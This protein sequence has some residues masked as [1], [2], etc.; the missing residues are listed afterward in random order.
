[1][2]SLFFWENKLQRYFHFVFL[3]ICELESIVFQFYC[4]LF[5]SSSTATFWI[6]FISCQWRSSHRRLLQ[7]RLLLK[8]SRILERAMMTMFPSSPSLLFHFSL[9]HSCAQLWHTDVIWRS[10]SHFWL[11]TFSRAL[12]DYL[13]I[14]K[15]AMVI[16]IL[17]LWKMKT[18]DFLVFFGNFLGGFP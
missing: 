15:H 7:P 4:I 5:S 16:Q 2:I 6:T 11:V 9:L 1:M 12:F 14:D 18:V 17:P 13:F 8:G 3:Q 10:R